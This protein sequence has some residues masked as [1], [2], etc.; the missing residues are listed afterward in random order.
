M[1]GSCRPDLALQAGFKSSLQFADGEFPV[2][3]AIGAIANG[4]TALPVG[5]LNTKKWLL[6]Q[7]GARW[8]ITSHDQIFVNVQKNMRQ[9][10]TYGGGGTSPWSLASQQAFDLF[11]NTVKPETLG[12]LRAGPA[13]QPRA[14]PRR[15]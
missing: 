13:Q 4:S 8:D 3:P 14:R 6:P 11:R 7:A 9:F 12:H 1:N 2:Q 10:P 5:K 15:R